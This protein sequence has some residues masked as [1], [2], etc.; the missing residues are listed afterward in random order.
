MTTHSSGRRRFLIQGSALGALTALDTLGAWAA[1]RESAPV[2]RAPSLFIG[3]G[4]PLNALRDNAF[5][6]SLRALGP[7]LPRPRAL[8]VVSAHW[9]TPGLS[10]VTANEKPPTIH[11]FRGFP[12]ELHA[13]QYPAPGAPDMAQE[14]INLVR[15]AKIVASTDWGFDHGTWTVLHH[16][17][18]DASLPVF[19]LSI[20]YS[21]P[22]AFHYQLGR[23]LQRMRDLGI[24]VI[25][26]GNVVHNLRATERGQP[27]SLR[28]SQTWAAAFDQAVGRA[29]QN[30]QDARLIDYL[31][32]DM[33][34]GHAVPT[35]DHYFPLLYTLGAARSDEV[36]RTTFTGFHSGTLSMRCFV[37]G[38]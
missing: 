21:R 37:F 14:V 17:Y 9:L 6:R 22:A 25:G 5:T 34:A 13:M 36:P 19:Q 2:M 8:L 3:H 38:A 29:L 32:L 10:A 35:P 12:A 24:M 4:S 20:D 15:G 26:S 23:E 16:L 33:S 28:A 7:V 1:A 18:P 31:S 27:E 30:R 11:D